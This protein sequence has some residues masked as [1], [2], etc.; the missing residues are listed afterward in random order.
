MAPNPQGETRSV[1][2][3]LALAL[4]SGL[5]TMALSAPNSDATRE[6]G[7]EGDMSRLLFNS[8]IQTP[9]PISVITDEALARVLGERDQ[10]RR[11]AMRTPPWTATVTRTPSP[12]ASVT[13]GH[14]SDAAI[15]TETIE[16]YLPFIKMDYGW[17]GVGNA[18][19]PGYRWLDTSHLDNFNLA[20]W[21]DWNH[22]NNYGE[23]QHVGFIPMVW[24]RLGPTDMDYLRQTVRANR[25][26]VWLVFNEPDHPPVPV[27]PTAVS[28]LTATPTPG[29]TPTPHIQYLQ[30]AYD[31]CQQANGGSPCAWI[32]GTTPTPNLHYWTE[33][34]ARQTADEYAD[35]YITI[36]SEDPTA[37]VFCCGQ[38]FVRDDVTEWWTAFLIR[39]RELKTQGQYQSLDLDGV[40]VHVYPYSQSTKCNDPGIDGDINTVFERCIR[41]DLTDYWDNVHRINPETTYKP[42]WITE[43]GYLYGDEAHSTVDSVRTGLMQRMAGFLASSANPGYYKVSWFSIALG[44]D[45]TRLMR[46]TP[47]PSQLTVLGTEWAGYDPRRPP[48]PT[49]TPTPP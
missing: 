16:V 26:R 29:D 31:M 19:D 12:R 44:D 7:A 47:P 30:C 36:K 34:I 3:L 32:K 43:Y 38:F 18:I 22:K 46:G 23:F 14:Q 37:K 41:G 45:R 9:R 13:P 25:N 6:A 11:R 33:R 48:S 1:W 8:P 15:T 5:I 39:F 40:H 27:T 49:A 20:W 35:I 4:V 2:P 42:L 24:C 21:Y 17:K 28:T 10:M